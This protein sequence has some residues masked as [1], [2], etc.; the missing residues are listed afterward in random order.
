MGK[1][2]PK[3]PDPVATA[4]AQTTMNKETALY[5]AGLNRINETT[6]Y[7]SSTYSYAGVDAS[8]VPQYNR[9]VTLDPAQQ[10]LLNKENAL[11]GQ[12]Y[13][14]A[15]NSFGRVQNAMGKDID[16]SGAPQLSSGPQ[17]GPVQTGLGGY[18]NVKT[19]AGF[20]P[21]A[22]DRGPVQTGLMNAGRVRGS[23]GDAGQVTRDLGQRGRITSRADSAGNI[24]NNLGFNKLKGLAGENDFGAERQRV[25]D[26]LYNRAATRLDRRFGMGEEQ[27]RNRLANQ[28]LTTG[29]EAW[30][31]AMKDFSEGRNDAY[32][33]AINDAIQAGGAEQSRL[34]GQSL[35]ARQQYAG[36]LAQQGQFANQA[37]GQRFGQNLS[38]AELANRAQEQDFAQRMGAGQFAN[39]AQQQA[40]GQN[41]AGAQFGNQAQ[42]QR[43]QQGLAAGQFGN[44]AQEQAFNQSAQMRQQGLAEALAQA[45]FQNEAQQQQYQ[46]ALGAGS[47]ANQ[48][49]QQA[50]QQAL[51]GSQQNNQARQQFFQEQAYL[52]NLPIN[53]IATLLGTG[54]GIQNPTFTTPGQAQAGEVD[55][56]G[57]VQNN[58]NQ[59]VASRNNMMSGLMGIGGQ[60]GGAGIMAA[61]SDVRMKHDIVRVGTTPVMGLPVYD[62]RYIHEGEDGPVHTGVM[63]QEVMEVAPDAVFM[64]DTGFYAVDYS[65]VA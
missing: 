36:E 12:M 27:L 4:Q 43:F 40:F 23:I 60:L 14:L 61:F 19:D 5:N 52:R 15:G 53:E 6:P 65:K 8:G 38:Q 30:N 42:Q 58:Y 9:T 54:G 47:F 49:Q 1:K 22:Y 57:M 18:G 37:Q 62:F 44:Q 16:L 39:Q 33:S 32:S 64:T 10:Q 25:E 35:S 48:A 21:T 24:G 46:Q 17:G 51:A 13:D 31:N 34:Y 26:A 55:Y 3:A 11:Q 7:G 20:N 50:Y 59:R 56:A 63:A 28:G 2:A 45:G 29:S 41:M